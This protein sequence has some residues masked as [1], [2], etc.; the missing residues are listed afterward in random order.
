MEK[1]S[2]FFQD[3]SGNFSITRLIVLGL[4]TYAM[5][6]GVYVVRMEGSVPALAYVSGIVGLAAGWKMGSKAQETK[7]KQKNESD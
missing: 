6:I 5:I 4:V 3:D 7:A 1:K 2:G